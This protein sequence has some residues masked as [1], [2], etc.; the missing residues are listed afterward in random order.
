MMPSR[1]TWKPSSPIG[2]SQFS[3][4]NAKVRPRAEHTRVALAQPR[5][6]KRK[7]SAGLFITRRKPYA[8]RIQVERKSRAL[9]RRRPSVAWRLS[10]TCRFARQRPL[11]R[12]G[13][14]GRVEVVRPTNRVGRY[15]VRTRAVKPSAS[16]REDGSRT[17]P[18]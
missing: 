17:P 11:G 13:M 7:Q 6:A 2:P 10:H 8:E 15:L 5:S 12:A 18:R 16:A 1:T 14:I 9:G 3:H 4:K